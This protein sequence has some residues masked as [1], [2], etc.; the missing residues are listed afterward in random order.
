MNNWKNLEVNKSMKD[1]NI[2]YL[3]ISSKNQGILPH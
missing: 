2:V 1:I 3:I